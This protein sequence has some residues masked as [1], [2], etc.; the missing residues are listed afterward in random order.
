V[1]HG[2]GDAIDEKSTDNAKKH[3]ESS[4]LDAEDGNEDKIAEAKLPA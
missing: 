1:E 2:F 4:S 3:T